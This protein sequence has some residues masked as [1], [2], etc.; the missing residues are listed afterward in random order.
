MSAFI[1]ITGNKYGRWTVLRFVGDKKWLCR[2]ECGKTGKVIG[3]HLKAGHSKSCGCFKAEESSRKLS[4]QLEGRVFG[5]LTAI[6]RVG[7]NKRN[8]AIW[9]CRCECGEETSVPA[10]KLITEQTRSCGCLWEDV[11]RTHGYSRTRTYKIWSH[12]RQRCLNPNV[13]V[14][15]NY[16]GRGISLCERWHS[17]ENFLADMGDAPRDHSI[18]RINVNGDYE[19]SNCRWATNKEQLRN[20]RRNKFV[21]VDGVEYLL[22]DAIAKLR[23]TAYRKNG[24]VNA[25]PKAPDV[26][27]SSTAQA[28]PLPA[29]HRRT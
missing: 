25:P 15:A 1:D 12:I 13:D 29:E 19:P 16:G 28:T 3:Q 20:T 11:I 9:L 8:N 2:C 22:T 21:M 4:A 5:R 23:A 6:K 17:Y 27:H 7:T 10:T 18:D 24:E 14:W 26:S